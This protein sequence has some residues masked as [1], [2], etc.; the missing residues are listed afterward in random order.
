MRILRAGKLLREAGDIDERSNLAGKGTKMSSKLIKAKDLEAKR[1]RR[2]KIRK[3]LAV[4]LVI[5]SLL[6]VFFWTRVAVTSAKFKKQMEQMVLG[7]DYFIEDI[8]IKKKYTYTSSY[9]QVFFIE[10]SRFFN[11]L[12]LSE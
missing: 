8:V 10:N 7:K 3:F 2:K 5:V 12:Y 1:I 9:N 6:F 4:I 11:L